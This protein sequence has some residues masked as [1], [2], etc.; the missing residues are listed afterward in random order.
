MQGRHGLPWGFHF[1]HVQVLLPQFLLVQLCPLGH[2]GPGSSNFIEFNGSERY[3]L[4]VGE[5]SVRPVEESPWFP[6]P[7]SLS[8]RSG[9]QGAFVWLS[10]SGEWGRGVRA[11]GAALRLSRH[12]QPLLSSSRSASSLVLACWL[13]SSQ[14]GPW[15]QCR[16]GTKGCFSDLVSLIDHVTKSEIAKETTKGIRHCGTSVSHSPEQS[17]L[18]GLSRTN[19]N[20]APGFV[21]TIAN[22]PQASRLWPFWP[23]ATCFWGCSAAFSLESKSSFVPNRQQLL[24]F[25]FLSVSSIAFPSKGGVRGRCS[26][27]VLTGHHP[28][29]V[30]LCFS[31]KAKNI[32]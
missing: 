11:A 30:E 29:N 14:E 20:V 21:I 6:R 19:G 31:F 22:K 10:R 15:R 25:F 4:D 23:V 13:C 17:Q 5:R 12:L 24:L 32:C 8:R 26:L 9:E 1:Y 18:E 16:R 27:W 28:F 3:G 2:P 7:R